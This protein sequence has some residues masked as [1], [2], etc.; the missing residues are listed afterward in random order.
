MLACRGLADQ[1]KTPGRRWGEPAQIGRK[2]RDAP[3]PV[4]DNE[5]KKYSYLSKNYFIRSEIASGP[6]LN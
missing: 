5:I 6:G 3:T 2:I 4:K 1:L